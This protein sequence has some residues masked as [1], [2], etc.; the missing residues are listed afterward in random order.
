MKKGDILLIPFP[1]TDLSG[2][3]FWP[4]LVLIATNTDITVAFITTQLKWQEDS[5]LK[6]EP[7]AENGLKKAS[8]VRLSKIATLDIELA[9]GKLGEITEPETQELNRKL[10]TLLQLD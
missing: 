4:A 6:L 2:L 10:R 1:F 9:T 8:L 5:D 7:S 3:K